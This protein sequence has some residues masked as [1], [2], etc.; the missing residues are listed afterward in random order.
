MDG[1]VVKVDDMG[2][3]DELGYTAHHPRWAMAFKFD[4]PLGQHGTCGCAIQVG[5][6]GRVTPV[7]ILKPVKLSGSVVTRATLH[8]QDYID[9]LELGIGDQVSISKRGDIIPAVEEVVE[10]NERHPSIYRL[11]GKCPFCSSDPDQGGSAS[12]LQK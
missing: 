5:R 6:N 9:L 10:K 11:P 8:N 12:L 3:R 7:A 4:A 2:I 1:L